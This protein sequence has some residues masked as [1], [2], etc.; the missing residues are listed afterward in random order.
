MIALQVCQDQ[1]KLAGNKMW[2]DMITGCRVKLSG[3][4]VVG[5]V[6]GEKISTTFRITSPSIAKLGGNSVYMCERGACM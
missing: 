2:L 3:Y 5:F 1:I 4:C 6:L